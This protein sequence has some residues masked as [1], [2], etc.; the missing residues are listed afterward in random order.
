MKKI[1]L[2]IIIVLLICCLSGCS[3]SGTIDSLMNGSGFNGLNWG[4]SANDVKAHA[5]GQK[6]S[7]Q[8]LSDSFDYEWIS[9]RSEDTFNWH[10]IEC[11]SIVF[12]IIDNKL[13]SINLSFKSFKDPKQG[14]KEIKGKVDSLL[15]DTSYEDF[16]EEFPKYSWLDEETQTSVHLYVLSLPEYDLQYCVLNMYEYEMPY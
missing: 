7:E 9:M 15:G 10:G 13:K 3:N 8:D 16:E 14:I 5:S 6:L 12:N 4:M 2:V 11:D 1:I